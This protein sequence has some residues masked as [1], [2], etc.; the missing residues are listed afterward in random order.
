[1]T[2]FTSSN[3][4]G[5]WLPKKFRPNLINLSVSLVSTLS[6]PLTVC[7]R[8]KSKP[9]IPLIPE[10]ATPIRCILIGVFIPKFKMS[11]QFSFNYTNC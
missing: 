6:D 2:R 7:P 3:C 1:M 5:E 10:P 8:L 11:G 4:S 9:A